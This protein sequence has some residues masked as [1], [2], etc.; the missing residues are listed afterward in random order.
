MSVADIEYSFWQKQNLAVL[1]ISFLVAYTSP[2]L[3]HTEN[4]L[5]TCIA[6]YKSLPRRY[7][8]DASVKVSSISLNPVGPEETDL[9][10]CI[11]VCE[12]V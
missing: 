4:W 2:V 10:S 6:G 8:D 11:N 7:R 9:V 3:S 12:N 5:R 1:E